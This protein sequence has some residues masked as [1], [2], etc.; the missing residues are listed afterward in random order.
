MEVAWVSVRAKGPSPQEDEQ[1][2]LA[3][4]RALVIVK[5]GQR[6]VNQRRSTTHMDR[7]RYKPEATAKAKNLAGS[8][9]SGVLEGNIQSTDGVMIIP[10]LRRVII[11]TMNV[12]KLNLYAKAKIPKRTPI[13]MVTGQAL[14]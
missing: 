1:T 8:Q 3:T 10:L 14:D 4:W 5:L 13:R 6:G 7:A 11:R 9:E 12:G 2:I